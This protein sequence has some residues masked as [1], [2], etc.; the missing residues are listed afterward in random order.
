MP[1]RI[2]VRLETGLRGAA[3]ALASFALTATASAPVLKLDKDVT[4]LIRVPIM[5]QAT[6]YTCGAASLQSILYYYGDDHYE[7]DLAKEL[8]SDPNEGTAYQSIADFA[9]KAGYKVDVQKNMTFEALTKR[10]DA[11]TPVL[12]LVQAWASTPGFDWA[13]AWDLGHYVVA[14]G[15]DEKNVYLMD[16][17]MTANYAYVPIAEFLD[18]WHDTDG[19]ERLTHFGM[20]ISKPR[21][22]YGRDDVIYM[23]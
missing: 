15:Y 14:V 5:R 8:G 16:P 18:R 23:E 3:L 13:N 10:L 22:T 12:V 6:D 19:T 20:T 7:S 9:K 2:L 1:S 4:S 11:G 21:A 17:V